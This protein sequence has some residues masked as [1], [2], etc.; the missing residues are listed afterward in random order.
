MTSG[1]IRGSKT[2]DAGST[3][4]SSSAI[5]NPRRRRSSTP[6]SRRAGWARRDR[7]AIS[8]T[9]R[10]EASCAS[11]GS[12]P[13]SAAEFP[14]EV[15]QMFSGSTLTK[16]VQGFAAGMARATVN[17]VS[18]QSRSSSAAHPDRRAAEKTRSVDVDGSLGHRAKASYA[19][20]ELSRTSMM[21]W[22]AG[23]MGPKS[24]WDPSLMVRAP[25]SASEKGSVSTVAV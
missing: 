17:D 20:T 21:G 2:S 15:A 9:T 5:D 3:P 19:A 18:R 14:M 24:P 25:P 12:I 6:R 7:S 10:T 1:A 16:T 13:D 23:T 8:T 11:R 4:T 22:N